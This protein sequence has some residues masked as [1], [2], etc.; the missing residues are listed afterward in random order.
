MTASDPQCGEVLGSELETPS[1]GT[2]C[3]T[4]AMHLEGRRQEEAPL[5]WHSP[6]WGLWLVFYGRV[7]PLTWV[8]ENYTREAGLGTSRT[9]VTAAGPAPAFISHS[10]VFLR[11]KENKAPVKE[12]QVS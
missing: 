3:C 2:S 7:V 10:Q 4:S 5:G 8:P 11:S 1:H 6:P 12:N 9:L